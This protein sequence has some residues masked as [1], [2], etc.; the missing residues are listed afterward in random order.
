MQTKKKATRVT[1]NWKTKL[2]YLPKVKKVESQKGLKM[3]RKK[4]QGPYLKINP[5]IQ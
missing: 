3:K 4:I 2:I 1:E 5:W